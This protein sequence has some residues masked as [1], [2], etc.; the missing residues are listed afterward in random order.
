MCACGEAGCA[1][2][3]GFRP[4]IVETPR[5]ISP[6]VH[7]IGET[8]HTLFR[9]PIDPTMA[10]EAPPA[11]VGFNIDGDSFEFCGGS[12]VETVGEENQSLIGHIVKSLVRFRRPAQSFPIVSVL[13][14][15]CTF[16]AP[17]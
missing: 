8:R 4:A 3:P 15:L 9:S 1:A 17:M 7:G 2:A 5:C 12:G 11:P 6:T 14:P 10:A 13:A 16:P